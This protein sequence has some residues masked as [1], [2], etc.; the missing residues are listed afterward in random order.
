MCTVYLM[1][2]SVKSGI[3]LHVFCCHCRKSSIELSS[4]E[5]GSVSM[6]QMAASVNAAQCISQMYRKSLRLT[7]E[8]IVRFIS[9]IK[10]VC[11]KSVN[12]KVHF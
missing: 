8:Q 7:S 6:R 5:D 1:F 10:S 11:D 2:A 3:I 4:D 12:V 9:T